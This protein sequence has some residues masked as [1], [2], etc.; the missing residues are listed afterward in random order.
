R[1]NGIDDEGR[2]LAAGAR[3][4]SSDQENCW[5]FTE[6]GWEQPICRPVQQPKFRESGGQHPLRFLC[7]LLC[8]CPLAD[9]HTKQTKETKKGRILSCARSRPQSVLAK[10]RKAV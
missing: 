4:K 6:K 2:A 9:F 5:A 3:Q 7:L 8:T 10:A 1:I